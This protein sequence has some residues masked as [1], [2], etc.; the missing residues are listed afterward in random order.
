[1]VRFHFPDIWLNCGG[2]TVGFRH[3]AGEVDFPCFGFDSLFNSR[4][5]I[6][7]TA[8]KIN[9]AYRNLTKQK[10]RYPGAALFVL[11]PFNTSYK[12]L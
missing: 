5:L 2:F 8:S 1:M 11:S 10:E 7:N 9:K 12:Q 4:D 6:G 3:W